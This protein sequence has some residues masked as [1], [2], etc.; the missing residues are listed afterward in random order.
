MHANSSIVKS[1]GPRRLIGPSRLLPATRAESDGWINLT[2]DKDVAKVVTAVKVT[3]LDK[4]VIYL[5]TLRLAV[6]ACVCRESFADVGD[7]AL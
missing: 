2:V 7:Q 6:H 4:K 1:C 5:A 3:D